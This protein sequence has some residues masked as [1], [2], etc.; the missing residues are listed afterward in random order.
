MKKTLYVTDLD[1]TLMRDDKTLS[2][3]TVNIIN[4]LIGN[5]VLITYA[6]SRSVTSASVIT[7]DI[8]FQMPVITLNGTI[9]TNLQTKEEDIA[10]FSREDLENLHQR[11]K[12]FEIPVAVTSYTNGEERKLYLDG[13]TN[14]GFRDYL[15][16]HAGDKRFQPVNTEGSLYNGS[17]CYFTF[18]AD[19]EELEPLYR[20]VKDSSRWICNYQ[21][22]TY[23]KEYWLEIAPGDSTKA[24]A[25]QKLQ[26]QYGCTRLVVFGD[27]LNDIPMFNIADEAYA[28][29][30]ADEKL[31]AVATGIIGSNNSDGVAEWLYINAK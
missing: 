7:K 29:A 1:G 20:Q 12:G 19:S 26:K 6:T 27:S 9:I 14:E 4:S 23:R 21:K 28:T 15:E 17:I 13:R 22:D 2:Q 5:G 10:M 30:N 3:N 8:N 18:M 11:V 31:K 24:K 16:S 25:I